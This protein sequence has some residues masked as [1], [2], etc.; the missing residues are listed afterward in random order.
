[1]QKVSPRFDV[2]IVGGGLAGLSLAVQ[3]RQ[4]DPT[5]EVALIEKRGLPFS[6]LDHKLGESCIEIAGRYFRDVLGFGEDLARDHILKRGFRV[7]APAGDNADIAARYEIGTNL[8]LPME[9]YSIDR[10]QFEATI[11]ERAVQVGVELLADSAVVNVELGKQHSRIALRSKGQTRTIEARWL[12]DA[13]GRS[14]LLRKRFGITQST[15][16][17][18]VSS[19]FR[20]DAYIDVQDWSSDREWCSRVPPGFRREAVNHLF[21]YGYWIWIIPLKCGATSIGVVANEEIQP[22]GELNRQDRLLEW[23]RRNEPKLAQEVAKHADRIRAFGAMRNVSYRASEFFSPERWALTGEA[24]AFNDPLYSTGSDLICTSNTMIAQLIALDRDDK[25]LE[26]MCAFMNAV[27]G[28]VFE[29]LI[30]LFR[31]QYELLGNPRV[32]AAKAGW[33]FT[34]YMCIPVSLTACFGNRLY[35]PGFMLPFAPSLERAARL[36]QRMQDFLREWDRLDRGPVPA[37]NSD[38]SSLETAM[39]LQHDHLHQLDEPAFLALMHDNIAILE[40]TALEV[41]QRVTRRLGIEPSREPRNPYA[42]GLDP[43]RWESEGLFEGD[44]PRP[45]RACV[46]RDVDRFW[47]EED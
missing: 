40:E 1:M 8:R 43:S 10:S 27:F 6:P 34:V 14:A 33:D 7:Y 41:F 11:A 24:A 26:E 9:T 17:P 22:F 39:R 42:I 47:I 12:V 25:P 21:G 37:G 30:G 19:W 3:L 36:A 18:I 23:L 2:C 13:S 32:Y 4:M 46:T 29:V 28:Q 20:L 31:G 5:L 44:E 15:S 16:H 35:D 38:F 45:P